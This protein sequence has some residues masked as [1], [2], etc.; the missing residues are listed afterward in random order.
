MSCDKL[1][2]QVDLIKTRQN[3][4]ARGFNKLN[5]IDM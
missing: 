3:Q 1:L 5:E 4:K 2:T